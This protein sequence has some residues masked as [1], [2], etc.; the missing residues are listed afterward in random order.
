MFNF[1]RTLDAWRFLAGVALLAFGQLA[2]AQGGPS[3]NTSNRYLSLPQVTVG[4]TTYFDV[5]IRVDSMAVLQVN[6]SVGG[7]TSTCAPEDMSYT[8]FGLI[9]LGMTRTQVSQILGCTD[10]AVVAYHATHSVH[11]WTSPNGSVIN[12]FFD[13]AGVIV[14]DPTGSGTFKT[15]L[16]LVS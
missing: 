4:N 12:V 9:T 3:Y 15:S 14:V 2:H 8:R 10:N 1:I 16:Y 6:S 7:L 5:V 11:A 13:L